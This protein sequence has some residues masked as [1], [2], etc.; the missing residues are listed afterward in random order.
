M[1]LWL[2]VARRRGVVIVG[3]VV[4]GMSFV[5][6]RTLNEE[7]SYQSKFRILVEPVNAENDLGN[8]T[9]GLGNQNIK[10]SLDYQTQIQVLRSPELMEV[11]LAEVQKTY[12]EISYN[13]LIGNLKITRLGKTKI[14]EISY[15]GND[16]DLILTIL[17]QLAK[18]YLNYSLNE[19]QT[20]LRQ[21]IQFIENQLPSLQARGNE[22]Q[23]QLQAFRERYQF[24]NP[25]SQAEL[26]ASQITALKQE[27]LALEQQLAKS[28]FN[29]GSLQE[30]TGAVAALS[31]A[32]LY[33]QII[34]QLREVETQIAAELTRFQPQSTAIRLL[35]NQRQ[36]LLPILEQEAERILGSKLAEAVTE[37]QRLETQRQTLLVAQ[38]QLKQQAKQ[39]P[40]LTRQYTDL[41]LEIQIATEGLNRFRAT[42][43]TLQIEAAQTE[44]P[45][46]VIEAPV[47]PV[48]PIS[49]N[50]QRS[51]TLGAVASLAVGIG[52]ALILEKLDHVY[53]TALELKQQSKLHLLG[54]IPINKQIAAT[55]SNNSLAKV[56]GLLSKPFT[57]LIPA[58]KQKST[59]YIYYGDSQS[60]H[61]LEA[62]RVLY[63]NIQLLSSD[64]PIR[65]LAI[66]S[67]LPGD[68]K[69]TIA[70]YLAQ[71][72]AA[73]GKKVLLV[74]ADLRKPQVHPRLQLSN[75][76]GLSNLI[77]QTLS[78][79]D[80]IEQK[81]PVAGLSVLTSGQLVPDPT[82]LIYSHKMTQLMAG[83]HETFDLV[84]YDTPSVLGLAD[85]SLL[86]SHT[87]G[88]ILV[89]RIG[90]TDRSALTQALENLKLSQIH[91]LGIVAN[92]VKGDSISPYKYYKSGYG[93]NHKEQDWE[94]EENLTPTLFK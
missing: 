7:P 42:W 61:F 53:H 79:E 13:S 44:I 48:A 55:P 32:P 23:N 27:N 45:W 81:L 34:G 94:E 47:R 12:P 25:D 74:D 22:L 26:I 31:E 30:E 93:N 84:I 16:P 37:V 36:N 63:T 2:G 66:S 9:P 35:Q 78:P 90:K 51:L 89:S 71:T 60:S 14:L 77:L 40:A 19:R 39:M 56:G 38:K 83:F 62:L 24:T 86:T 75:Q 15:Q 21:G 17:E 29:L 43:E 33:Q 88:L 28:R 41:E 49:P 69:S 72:A 80:V 6:P 46:E 58:L 64:R 65:S 57:W 67:A 85:A 91:V 18:V 52:V 10:S 1:G 92:G 8:L 3:V 68:G 11:V 70:I 4:T 5:I 20:N 59:P 76:L 73:I 87:D 82:K 50:I 54:N